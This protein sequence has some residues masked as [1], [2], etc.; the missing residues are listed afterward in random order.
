VKQVRSSIEDADSTSSLNTKQTPVSRAMRCNKAG[1]YPVSRIP[2]HD[3]SSMEEIEDVDFKA[4]AMVESQDKNN[5][6]AAKNLNHGPI[7]N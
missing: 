1:K 4:Q 6:E 2:Y 3:E 5:E 7:Q